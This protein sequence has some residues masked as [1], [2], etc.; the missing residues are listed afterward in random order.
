MAVAL[1][2]Q[3]QKWAGLLLDL[4]IYLILTQKVYLI[5]AVALYYTRYIIVYQYYTESN[6]LLLVFSYLVPKHEE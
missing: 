3:E 2:A 4:G 1:S 5:L 6:A